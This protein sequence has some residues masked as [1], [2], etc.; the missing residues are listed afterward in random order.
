MDYIE[1]GKSEGAR[2]LTGGSRPD[3]LAQGYFVDPTIFDD[4]D[5]DDEDLQGRDLRAGAVRRRGR[6]LEEALRFANGV[7]YGLTTSI[8]T[9]TST[10]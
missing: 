1:T 9:R 5:P 4:V 2:L 3:A 7:E 6:S 8:F 10:R